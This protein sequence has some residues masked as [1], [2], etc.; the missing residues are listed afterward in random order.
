MDKRIGIIGVGL[1][2][3]SLGLALKRAGIETVGYDRSSRARK[4]ADHC[5]AGFTD[6]AREL[7]AAAD[8]VVIACPLEGC[9][10][11]W[12]EIKGF[13]HKV[14]TDVLST[15]RTIIDTARNVFGTV[16]PG[17]VPGHPIAGTELSGAA[18][19]RAN[20]FDRRKVFLTPLADTAK[21]AVETVSAMWRAVGAEIVQIGIEEH[22][23]I[24]ATTSH[25]PHALAYTLVHYVFCSVEKKKIL[26]CTGGGFRDFSRIA[27]SSPEM[28]CDICLDNRKN[29]LAAVAG[30][31]ESLAGL[32]D[33]LEKND[34][35]ALRRFFECAAAYKKQSKNHS[36]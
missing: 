35:D 17:F 5:V 18:H 23:R 27:E 7:A 12:L 31:R 24:L 21:T 11:V 14:I 16:P 30:F 22:D 3:G 15:K 25:L 13:E 8:V 4:E 6:S 10:E 34:G 32:A 29:L 2:G 33:A 26:D 20:L 36:S 9:R 28:W 1:I 19:A